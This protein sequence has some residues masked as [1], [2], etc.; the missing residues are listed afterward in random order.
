MLIQ[1]LP[2]LAQQHRIVLASA[3]PRRKELLQQ[4]GLTFDIHVST[5]AED[6][7]KARYTPVQ[8]VRETA[9]CKAHEVSLRLR[10]DARPPTL[11]IGADTV[12]IPP[13]YPLPAHVSRMHEAGPKGGARPF[14]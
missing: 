10:T 6:L 13:S 7:D 3:S 4:I 1:H 5:F 14:G 11:V 9:R 12:A 2:H 8:Y